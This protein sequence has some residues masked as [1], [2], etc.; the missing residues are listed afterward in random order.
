MIRSHMQKCPLC[1]KNIASLDEAKLF[2]IQEGDLGKMEGLWTDVRER[3]ST[4]DTDKRHLFWP[5]WRWAAAAAVAVVAM[6]V[7][8]WFYS[9][10]LRNNGPAEENMVEKFQIN[11]MRIEKKPAQTYVFWPQGTEMI[12]VWAEKDI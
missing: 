1:Q 6:V 7:G 5:R 12:L 8:F 3:L 10:S 9:I 2:L 11:Y 4:H